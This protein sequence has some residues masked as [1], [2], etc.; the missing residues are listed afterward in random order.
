MAM[1]QNPSNSPGVSRMSMSSYHPIIII[2]ININI[3]M[4]VVMVM[5]VSIVSVTSLLSLSAR[6]VKD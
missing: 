3:I 4:L 1:D 6:L 5:F 2:N